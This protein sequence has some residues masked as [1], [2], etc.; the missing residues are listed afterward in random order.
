MPDVA[1]EE[2]YQHTSHP[3]HS[4][5]SVCLLRADANG[6]RLNEGLVRC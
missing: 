6:V 2:V 3:A 1:A 4:K 5:G